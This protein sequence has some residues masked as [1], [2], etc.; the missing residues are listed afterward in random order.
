MSALDR[1]RFNSFADLINKGVKIDA[2]PALVQVFLYYWIKIGGSSEAW[3][4]LPFLLCG[5][6][7]CWFVF[8]F[9]NKWFDYKTGVI[10]AIVVSCSMIFLIYSSYARMYATGVLFAILVLIYLFE[11]AFGNSIKLKDYVLLGL[12]L[13]LGAL[14]NHMG[15]L[16]GLI[17][18]LL[19]FIYAGKKQKLY[20]IGTAIAAVVLYLPHLSITLTQMG[21]SIGA[22][23][24]GWLTAPRW[25]ACFGFLKTVFGTGWVIYLLILLLIYAGNSTKFSFIYDKKIVFLLAIFILY[26]LTIQLYSV[27]KNPILQF[28]VLLIAAPCIVIVV[29]RGLSFIPDKIFPVAAIVLTGVFLVQT[30][31]IKKYYALGI[32][33]GIHSS[34]TQTIAAKAKYGADSVAAI[35]STEAFFARHYM[36]VY[37]QNYNYLTAFDSVFKT[38][39]LLNQYLKTLKGK[40]IILSDPDAFLLE[41]T[42]V[43]FPYMVYHDEG[44]F[45]S[46][47]LFSK[48]KVDS[49]KDETELS[50]NTVH[51]SDGFVFPKKFG[52]GNNSVLI[53]S[54]NEFPFCVWADIN[55]LHLKDGEFV[56]ADATFKTYSGMEDLSVDFNI[57]KNDSTIF[58]AGR[59]FKDAYMPDDVIQHGFSAIFIGTD[60]DKWKDA[61]L[62]C[63]FWNTGKKKYLVTDFVIKIID[64]NPHKYTLWD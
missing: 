28:S 8:K 63:Y 10:A 39:S 25:Y 21:Y 42:K 62:E 12:F 33:Q 23:E 43:Y 13:L 9:S 41:R 30:I 4:K 52:P 22:G 44:Y 60:L 19:S 6:F 14:S 2:H 50:V 35:Y 40:Y 61:K 47:F 17:A 3:V 57:K 7:S 49:T 37:K 51:H 1:T 27:Y 32:K 20:L 15:A 58:Y 54:T 24:G 45:K 18:G 56:I 34:I 46:I 36:D 29:A 38:P 59:N 26:C 55:A 64:S 31:Y 11:I 48:A 5:F 16:F 53:D